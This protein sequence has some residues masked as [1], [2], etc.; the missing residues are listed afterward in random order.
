VRIG[1][2][3]LLFVG[4][5]LR[6][7]FITN[8]GFKNDVSSFEGW[9]LTLA[10]HS[11]SQF[12]SKAGFA[13]YPPGYFYILAAVG[14]LWE[15]FFKH[16]DTSYNALK[17]LVKLPAIIADLLVGLL[18]FR[19]VRRFASE[20]WAL[21]AA[22]LYVLNPAV[23]FISATWG[24]VDSISGGLALLAIYLLLR[25]Q[26][27]ERTEAWFIGG[28]WVAL[29]YSILI[30][31]Q[32]AIL[33]PLL[34]AFAFV[35]L[36]ERR[37]ARLM[38]TGYGIVAALGLA[39][40]LSLPFHPGNPLNV[41]VWLYQ[42][43]SYGSG[44]YAFN[45]VNAFNLWSIRQDFWEPDNALTLF[46]PQYLW[47]LGL[48]AA[49]TLLVLWRY[50]QLCI[51]A[52]KSS[53]QAL[54]ESAAILL[55]AFFML[56]TRMHERYLFDGFLFTIACIP[57]AWRY[58][59][60]AAV[61]SV[62]LFAN[63][64]YSLQYLYVMTQPQQNP[65]IDG[66]NLWGFS[67]H[68]LS[69]VNVLV[70]FLLGYLFLGT[71]EAPALES[72]SAKETTSFQSPR[73]SFSLPAWGRTWFDPAEGLTAMRGAIDYIVAGALGIA[74]FVLSYVNYWLPNEKIFDE[75]Y[76]ARAGEEYLQKRPIYESTHPPLTKLLVTLSMTLFGGLN[77]HTLGDTPHGWRFLDVLFGALVVVL[78]YVFAKRVTGSTIFSA[79]AA[80][81]LMCDG[82]HFVQS[83]IATP[84]GFVVFFSV[85]AVYAFYRFW[86]ASQVNVRADGGER[87]NEYALIASFAA[88]TVGMLSSWVFVNLL[89]HQSA[90][91]TIVLGLY[92][93]FG[94]Y[95][96]AR[97]WIIPKFFQKLDTDISF[98][99][100]S[101]ALRS[102]DGSSALYLP[103]GRKADFRRGYD[104]GE[105]AIAYNRDIT[106]EYK[107]PET[108]ARYTPGEI[109]VGDLH[110][111]GKDA[112]LWLIIFTV[113]LGCL[114]ASKWYGVMGF[115]V[116]FV[117]LIAIWL[118]QL[119]VKRPMLWGNPRGFR[120]DVA[121]AT[122]VFI[123]ATVYGLSWTKDLMNHADIS[124]PTDVVYRQYS[125]F[126]YHDTLKATH[127][128]S[129]PWWEWP[130]DLRPIA[131]YYKDMRLKSNDPTA[132][133]VAE[134]ISLPNP[135][136][137]WLGLLTVPIVGVLA[138]LKRNKAYALIVLTYLLQW[139][140]WMRSPRIT[141]AYHFYVDIPL[142]CLCNVIVMQ[143]VW[144]EAKDAGTF[145]RGL[146]VAGIS[147]YVIAVI[148][149]F[150]FFYPIL[151]GTPI[152]W[153][154]WDARMWHGLMGNDWI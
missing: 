31:P 80:V 18:L 145:E 60:G 59:A 121:L 71:N 40:L 94:L 51:V 16:F 39:F 149:A 76:F 53:G 122:I 110:Q 127:P 91:A 64:V 86:I 101:H 44:V 30:K 103:D 135:L 129:S 10:E 87:M 79:I 69:I 65:D 54:L 38:A 138:W 63:L 55:L 109:A 154:A 75:I 8:D 58:L 28:A 139:L 5:I 142:I 133:C 61:L 46:L 21:G 43:Y 29:G 36:A 77:P 67:A 141:F 82:M 93:S 32:A 27:S 153:N 123:S 90:A 116:S 102:A 2:V 95:L 113:A 114:V 24:Q 150:I 119:W 120:L 117:V 35:G 128:Y 49:A 50:L 12:Y 88:L 9:A 148:A 23:I 47:G 132:C 98:P 112:R 151:A 72:D 125:M 11:F 37:P 106:V 52:A 1:L 6:L 13:D 126:E 147:A 19:I 115:G 20:R 105:L 134:I 144:K 15:S 111:R 89:G 22:A 66:H 96:L 107:T 3:V 140:P 81:L 84:E 41:F 34:V 92:A 146:A 42:R 130:L 143:W 70:F 104:D 73:K 100:G 14:A 68:L 99:D 62:T 131:Y 136:I 137:L 7:C 57:F 17:I 56:S 85:A 97:L 45:S 118:Q 108:T 78:L 25:S 152:P 33:I 74:A 83:R 48:L 26:D 124:N 4:F